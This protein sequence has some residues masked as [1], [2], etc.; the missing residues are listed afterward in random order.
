MSKPTVEILS[1]EECIDLLPHMAIGRIATTV[2]GLPILFLVSY[3]VVDGVV[4]RTREGTKLFAATTGSVVAFQVDF[5]EVG[6]R[7]GWSVMV[8]EMATTEVDPARLREVGLAPRDAWALD[9]AA[10]HVVR[11][12]LRRAS[13][14]RFS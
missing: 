10:D 9:G 12:E 7:S 14:R 3:A 1:V 2:D 6:G 11:I 5:F 4:F 8:R 13:G